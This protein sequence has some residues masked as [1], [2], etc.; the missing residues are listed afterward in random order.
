MFSIVKVENCYGITGKHVVNKVRFNKNTDINKHIV[1]GVNLSGKT[2]L[3]KVLKNLQNNAQITNAFA[4]D[5]NPKVELIIGKNKYI[6]NNGWNQKLKDHLFICDKNFLNNSIAI[7]NDEALIGIDMKGLENIRRTL[8]KSKITL[9]ESKSF[10]KDK[11]GLDYQR[12][13]TGYYK[14]ISLDK[15]FSTRDQHINT[16]NKHYELYEENKEVY[17]HADKDYLD[18]KD[19]FKKERV[20]LEIIDD[21]LK[22][23]VDEKKKIIDKYFIKSTHDAEFYEVAVKYLSS[24][25]DETCPICLKV[26][27]DNF[28]RED[29]IKEIKTTLQKHHQSDEYN[30]FLLEREKLEDVDATLITEIG[31]LISS[32][33]KGENLLDIESKWPALKLKLEQVYATLP[34]FIGKELKLN[35]S[36]R[37]INYNDL[38][39]QEE[40][41]TKKMAAVDGSTLLQNFNDLRKKFKLDFLKEVN[42][43]FDAATGAIK[44]K[45]KEDS[46]LAIEDYHINNSS[47][48][49]KS[50]LSLLFFFAYVKTISKS[51]ELLLVFDDPIDS[52][53]NY[54]KHFILDLIMKNVD[55]LNALTIIFT[56]SSDT[57]R[58]IKLNYGFNCEFYMMTR[59]SKNLIFKLSNKSLVIFDG[60]FNFYDKVFSRKGNDMYLDMVALLPLFRDVIEHSKT[61]KLEDD[62]S[63]ILIELYTELS[64]EF[65]HFNIDGNNRTLRDLYKIYQKHLKNFRYTDD[66]LAIDKE[67]D[68]YHAIKTIDQYIIKRRKRRRPSAQNPIERI[69]FKNLMAIYI[70]RVIERTIFNSTISRLKCKAKQERFK[71]DFKEWHT[72]SIKQQEIKNNYFELMTDENKDEMKNLFAELNKYKH[73]TNDYHHQINSYITPMLEMS[74]D[75]MMEFAT[76]IDQIEKHYEVKDE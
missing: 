76:D 9:S 59:E 46:T 55:K 69:K 44:I 6:Y 27:S 32:A 13:C 61:L 38:K 57:T 41:I 28:T 14:E 65:L 24:T 39:K 8:E 31:E 52:H 70:R 10:L 75:R 63:E 45:M 5:G 23:L 56:H 21:Y 17:L 36:E 74:L 11:F 3:V 16:I 25:K 71:E 4:K 43:S 48:G 15:Y 26:Y 18:L 58:S 35:F 60:P 73:I 54:N 42:A 19:F 7:L 22:N 66:D 64:N 33:L 40:I 62:E 49:E 30:K 1:F 37:L 68:D 72:I 51:E 67:K 12:E 20:N 53:D 50:I 29:I 47:E 34:L 2:S